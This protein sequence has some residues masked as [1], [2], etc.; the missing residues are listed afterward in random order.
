[1]KLET[2]SPRL[3]QYEWL[4]LLAMF[5][6]VA[7]HTSTHGLDVFY[8]PP[9]FS[10]PPQCGL[11]NGL[12]VQL[13]LN[14]CSVGVNIYILITGYFLIT[15]SGK[16]RKLCRIWWQTLLFALAAP[17]LLV[18]PGQVAGSEWQWG[19]LLPLRNDVYWFVTRYVALLALAPFLSRLAQGLS[20]KEYALLLGI[21]ALLNLKFGRF[22]YGELFS[23]NNSLL[24]FIFLYLTGGFLRLWAGR[25]RWRHF[26][27]AYLGFCLATAVAAWSV[28]LWKSGGTATSL[29]VGAYNGTH[30]ISALLLF[31][32]AQGL[33]LPSGRLAQWICRAAPFTFGVYLLHDHPVVRHWLW[34]QVFD[35]RSMADSPW[36]LACLTGVSVGVFG[37]S[38]L[39]SAL[40]SPLATRLFDILWAALPFRTA[41]QWLTKGKAKLLRR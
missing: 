21:L 31:R 9:S 40:L 18:L 7:L 29:I 26:G 20:R 13:W 8:H 19:F 23:G 27:T 2:S 17:L 25:P 3:P 12:L 5:F 15:A 4:R 11:V 1:M 30:F 24:F 39:L 35:L 41:G 14:L 10:A 36:L 6:I 28:G 32:W 37:C 16:W 34:H 38:L 22:L 33:T